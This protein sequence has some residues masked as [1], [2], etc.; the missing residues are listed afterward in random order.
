MDSQQLDILP[1]LFNFRFDFTMILNTS[2]ILPNLVKLNGVFAYR[3]FAV[4]YHKRFLSRKY[5]L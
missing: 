1:D 4:R 3:Q 5:V 2:H